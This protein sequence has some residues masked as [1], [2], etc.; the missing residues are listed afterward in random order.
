MRDT[1]QSRIEKTAFSIYLA[2]Q[3]HYLKPYEVRPG[4]QL[5]LIAIKYNVPWQYLTKLNRVDPQKIQAGQ[6]LKV[7]RGPFSAVVD[8]S[9]FRLTV[10]CQGYYVHHYQVGIG[11]D[12]SSPIGRFRVQEKL[13][14]PT[15]Y[16]PDGVVA[17]GNPCRIIRE[18]TEADRDR[19]PL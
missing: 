14:N 4:D 7:I 19:K 8:L 6:K 16:G 3:P 18:I 10:H 12:G 2:P 13:E 9:D 1:I 11:K 17:A 5:R 15:Y